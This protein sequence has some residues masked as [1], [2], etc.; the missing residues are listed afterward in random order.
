MVNLDSDPVELVLFL[1]FHQVFVVEEQEEQVVELVGVQV[2][3]QEAV[4]T[5]G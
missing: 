3:V 2:V 4:M 1:V 5:M